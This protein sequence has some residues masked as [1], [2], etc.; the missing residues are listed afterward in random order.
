MLLSAALATTMLGS[1]GLT[2]LASADQ[3]P[4]SYLANKGKYY[5]DFAN[6]EEVFQAAKEVNGEIV[7]EGAVLL[8]NNGTLPLDLRKDKKISIFG[9]QADNLQEGV[10]GSVIA[11]N[12]VE[13][14]GNAFRNA[15][16]KV[17]AALEKE[18]AAWSAANGRD[19]G[20]EADVSKFSKRAQDSIADYNDAAIVVLQRVDCAED[21]D[22]STS[23]TG[24]STNAAVKLDDERTWKDPVTGNYAGNETND[25]RRELQDEVAEG[26][27]LTDPYG[28]KHANS[29]ITPA[30]EGEE[31]DANGYV[32]VKH[33]LQL[34]KSEI[35]LLDY[36]KANFDK[37][38]VMFNS[39]TTFEC[40]NLEKDEEIDGILWFGRPGIQET[41]I[42]AVAKIISGE[43]NP[44]G[45][46]SA[47]WSRDFTADPTWQNTGSGRQFRYM[48]E[49][50]E[51][52]G[53]AG[54]ITAR[55]ENGLYTYSPSAAGRTGLNGLRSNEYE[56]GIYLGYKYY[57]TVYAE[58]AMGNLKYDKANDVLVGKD[59]DVEGTAD[60]WHE[61]NVVYPFGYGLSY[62]TFSFEIGNVTTNLGESAESLAAAKLSS[63][64]GAPAAV[65]QL[66]VPVTVE[67]TG[68]VAG[69]Q[70]VELYVSAPYGADSPIEK[71]AVKLVA[72]GKTGILDPGEKETIVIKVDVQDMAS[73]DY[74]DINGND[75]VGYEMEEG[76]YKLYAMSC[77]STRVSEE[78]GAI[79]VFNF[80][81]TGGDATMQ[82]DDHTDNEIEAR[83]SDPNATDYSI[84]QG[85]EGKG[86][87][88]KDADASMTILSRGDILGTFPAAL[89]IKDLTYKDS[90]IAYA[91]QT[92][93]RA[94]NEW[95][96]YDFDN[97]EDPWYVDESEFAE[98]GKYANWTQATAEDVANRVD[99]KTEVQ[100]AQM[101]GVPIDGSVEINGKEWTW[102]D[103]MN[104][105]TFDEVKGLV[106]GNGA[107]AL[108]S[109]GKAKDSNA[110]RPLNLAS[111]FTW[112]D[113]P[114]QSATFNTELIHRLGEI[115]GEFALQKESNGSS[116]GQTSGWWGPGANTNRTPFLGRTKEYYSQDGILAGYI[117]AASVSGAAEKGCKVYIKHFLFYGNEAAHASSIVWADEQNMREN[118]F[119]A[120]QRIFQEGE[121]AAVM[122]SAWRMNIDMIGTQWDIMTGVLRNEWGWYGE[123]ASDMVMGQRSTAWTNPDAQ[124]L[125]NAADYNWLAG[126][127][128]S[129]EMMLRAGLGMPMSGTKPLGTWNAEARNG[130]GAV[131]VEYYPTVKADGLVKETSYT[132]YY[133][134]REAV[135]ATLFQCANSKVIENGVNT[136]KFAN[137]TI[138]L[139]QYATANVASVMTEADLNGSTD[140]VYK[141]YSGELPEG[142]T[143]NA[144]GAITGTANNVGATQA[145]IQMVVDG[146]V[147][148]TAVYTINVAS[149][150]TAPEAVAEAN[151]EYAGAVLVDVNTTG[152]TAI[153]YTIAEGALPTGLT[154][155]V[156]T[157]MIEGTPTEVGTYEFV[158]NLA[159]TTKSGRNT[160][161]KNYTSETF[162]ITVEGEPAPEV[163]PFEIGENGNW[164][165][166]GEDTGIPAT[167]PKGDKG[168][169][170][171]AGPQG[172]KGETGATG[173][174]GAQ[175]PQGEKGEAGADGKDTLAALGC[176]SS[177]SLGV[178]ALMTL[179][180][181]AVVLRKKE[182]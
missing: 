46:A 30:L 161:T 172:E 80:E 126:S 61:F 11:P 108:A 135:K 18:Y 26:T 130:L 64:T 93:Q 83:F 147:K 162:T 16:F 43:I 106:S 19:E 143:I 13:T 125:E 40:Y 57:E 174:T 119:S 10:N 95:Y 21:K 33:D 49:E 4:L 131:E 182:D 8:K 115:V 178:I 176:T 107:G 12:A 85:G 9:A 113:A 128:C 140:V 92:T 181:A 170:G 42:T 79:D 20:V 75:F 36:V 101:A 155:D 25:N 88:N 158:I 29:S 145:T 171:A 165:I 89:T 45:G 56:E 122:H 129:T 121:V 163:P 137:R 52:E 167:G 39:S 54:N 87:V 72:F 154:L 97:P 55:Y 58:L 76:D 28:W 120:F 15:G 74:N 141:V 23:L 153:E 134:I 66:Y 149:A 69:K 180:G 111:T 86:Q 144:A 142:L 123:N 3:L 90:V 99:G 5:S 157:G 35:E 118:Y 152:A 168:D 81:V 138:E 68:T 136:A 31:G 150:W 6:I 38:I 59:A 110:D 112:A 177:I 159:V 71:A 84:R 105:M 166:N 24:N 94:N 114:V 109:I 104:Q 146:W 37:V 67:N 102:D 53:L 91:K 133:V 156:V 151:E 73:F 27:D 173:A 175:G 100:L 47:Q 60:D 139:K 77:S 63:A 17:N 164:F 7:A 116:N 96:G 117:G 1:T 22:F 41:G 65:K 62:T 48:N 51:Y 160:V 98:G 148:K 2:A 132:Q 169:T 70:A 78:L 44:S 127:M 179:A 32:E 34:T 14:T 124:G 82:L 103:F 50:G